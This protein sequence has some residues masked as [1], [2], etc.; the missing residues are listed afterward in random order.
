M[1]GQFTLNWKVGVARI[2]FKVGD[3]IDLTLREIEADA[4]KRA[5]IRKAYKRGKRATAQDLAS[6]KMKLKGGS[7]LSGGEIMEAA[8]LLGIQLHES[9]LAVVRSEGRG[10]K[11]L[12]S[13]YNKTGMALREVRP[14]PLFSKS[15][16]RQGGYE[17]YK[18]RTG[19][20]RSWTSAAKLMTSQARYDIRTSTTG[21][22]GGNPSLKHGP[23]RGINLPRNRGR[24]VIPLGGGRY[25]YGGFLRKNIEAIE[26]TQQGAVLSG[27]V[28]SKAPYSRYVEFPTSRTKAQ[29]FLL[30]ALK[31]AR[32]RFAGNITRRR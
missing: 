14:R 24:G 10:S 6:F 7:S 22:R 3:G 1:S 16:E 17:S 21:T 27:K 15:G 31:R 2:Q 11:G 4:I 32:S 13:P 5:P 28:V 12:N 30:P 19:P 29:P 23:N 26:A 9:Q 8:S 25:Q 18:R 20:G